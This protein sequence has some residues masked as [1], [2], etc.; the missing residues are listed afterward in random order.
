VAN[1]NS[2]VEDRY[3]QHLHQIEKLIEYA[4]DIFG[5]IS[6]KVAQTDRE[7]YGEI[8]FR[9]AT[10]HAISLRN[11][12]PTG[13]IPKK[14]NSQE[15][16]DIST[17][18]G[19]SRSII[20]AFDMLFF[21]AI[22]DIETDEREF[23]LIYTN[24]HGV[25][26]TLEMSDTM[27]STNQ[28]INFYTSKRNELHNEI[29]KH[30]FFRKI[31]KKTKSDIKKL[32]FRPFYIPQKIR[33]ERA[34]INHNYYQAAKMFLSSHTHTHPFSINQISKFK[35]GDE[36]SLRLISAPL[37]YSISFYCKTL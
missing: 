32:K 31:D 15:I 37:Q 6:G 33:N 36:D 2:T 1:I 7:Y 27:K 12:L 23:R 21:T 34:G 16:W 10:A 18:C 24:L 29:I 25:N 11:I 8:I 13:L 9:K 28:N 20:E 26:Q 3:L 14:P 19:I 4:F 5:Q 22:E 17:A 35:A 30:P